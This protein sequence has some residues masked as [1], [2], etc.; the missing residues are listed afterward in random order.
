MTVNPAREE[1]RQAT[2]ELRQWRLRRQDA[3]PT[4]TLAT[5]SNQ[6][7]ARPAAV[8]STTTTTAL[9]PSVQRRATLRR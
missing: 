9:I 1:L 3:C 7:T 5:T 6:D 2:N 4:M 8:V